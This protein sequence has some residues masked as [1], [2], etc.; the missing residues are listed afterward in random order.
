MTG[1]GILTAIGVAFFGIVLGVLVGFWGY[2]KFEAFKAAKIKEVMAQFAPPPPTVSTASA[3]M[4]PW[5]P[6]LSAVGNVRAAK[7]AD[8]ATQVAGIVSAIRFESGADVKA[9]TLLLELQSADDAARLQSLKAAAALAKLTLDRD[10][11]QLQAQ[12]ISQQQVDTDA[13]NLKSAEAQVAQ[14]EALLSYKSIRAPFDGRL[15]I[16]QVDLGQYVAAGA[17]VVTLQELDLVYVD[18]YLP[19]QA[20]D[21]LKIDQV[22]TAN[23]DTFPGQ[24]FMGKISAINP[25]V[26]AATR[27]VL[28]RA[29]FPNPEKKL[30]PG[31]FANVHIAVGTPE[32]LVTLPQTAI[33]YNPYGD[34]VYVVDD[35]GKTPDGKPNLVA[36]QSFVT[37][38]TA[39]GDLIAILKGVKEGETVVVAGQLKL[40]NGVNVTINNDQAPKADAKPKIQEQ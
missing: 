14:Q 4:E 18:F 13:Q 29:S 9:G 10:Q 11:R 31:M 15:G 3:T 27:N 35:K 22:V 36:R 28:V 38:G 32:K 17:S 34:T 1:R 12:A 25:K 8:L 20:L 37:T 24:N 26:D 21:R 5:Q 40:R 6:E 39:K 2:P 30:V 33:S 19:Q 7:G 16:R 23:I